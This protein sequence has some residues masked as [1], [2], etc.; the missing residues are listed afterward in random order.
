MSSCLMFGNLR[1][2]VWSD[3]YGVRKDKQGRSAGGKVAV[4][5]FF[6]K[7]RSSLYPCR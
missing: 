4:F 5:G 3:A 7:T 1:N 6:K 2:R